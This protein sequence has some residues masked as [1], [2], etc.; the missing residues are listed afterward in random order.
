MKKNKKTNKSVL[1]N[2]TQKKNIEDNKKRL[3]SGADSLSKDPKLT[4]RVEQTSQS[5]HRGPLPPP[6]ILADYEKACPGSMD[7]IISMAE[8]EQNFSHTFQMKDN[9]YRLFGTIMGFIIVIGVL[10]LSSYAIYLDKSWI[11][12]VLLSILATVSVI[13]GVARIKSKSIHKDKK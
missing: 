4:V 12:K 5:I 8:K 2:I 10:L 6:E 9:Q 13:S 7:R 1:T 11:V 3:L